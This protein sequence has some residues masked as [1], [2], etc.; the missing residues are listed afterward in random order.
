MA[1]R[2]E[3][4]SAQQS[5]SGVST[6]PVPGRPEVWREILAGGNNFLVL[7][8]AVVTALLISGIVV[9][10]SGRNPLLAYLGLFQGS[11]GSLNALSG[12]ILR[13]TPLVFTG[14]SVALGFKCGLFNIGGNGQLVMGAL[15]GAWLGSSLT[16]L[17]ALLHVPLVLAAGLVA[18]GIWGAI[19]G[20]LKARTGAHEVINTI[21]LNF[22]AYITGGYLTNI[23][24]GI[25][26]DPTP[27]TYVPRT[28]PLQPS[29]VLDLLVAEYQVARGAEPLV[30]ERYIL[31]PPSTLWAAARGVRAVPEFEF[32]AGI[33]IAMT[34]ALLVYWFLWRTP[35]GLAIRCV[36]ANP[37]AAEYGGINVKRGMVLT[38]ALCGALAGTAG[39]LNVIDRD[40]VF[41]SASSVTAGFDGIAVALLG[42]NHPAGI[43][44]AAILFGAFQRS[45]IDLQRVSGTPPEIIQIIQALVL[46]FVAAEA[47]IRL[48]Y[49]IREV[50]RH[51]A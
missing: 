37:K 9:W 10:V 5:L 26:K 17:P 6:G 48:I 29:A 8:L 14:L 47:I 15:T 19:P 42:R 31:D 27:F 40:Y 32:H 45:S 41:N 7:V 22:V 23:R 39:V 33:L 3:V 51:T 50:K 11:F 1:D 18:G 44:L 46:M 49:R 28:P 43:V 13:A 25:L 12:S 21:M 20:F 30:R 2:G 34:A 24:Y 4:T 35:L 16:G 38:M 36:G